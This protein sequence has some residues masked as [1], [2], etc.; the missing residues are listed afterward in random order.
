MNVATSPFLDLVEP[1]KAKP[2]M[3]MS[4][5]KATLSLTMRAMDPEDW[6]PLISKFDGACQEMTRVFAVNRWPKV[7]LEPVVFLADG[8]PVAG[9]MVMVQH[10]PLGVGRMAIIKWGPTMRF[11]DR[12]DTNAIYEQAIELLV[13]EYCNKRKM[14]MSIMAR[15][16][17][18]ETNAELE[19]LT[20]KGFKQGEQLKF[21]DRYIVNLHQDDDELRAGLGQKWRYHFKK[22]EKA[23]LEFEHA[24]GNAK[25]WEFDVLYQ[26]MTDRKRFPDYSAYH[27]VEKLMVADAPELRP[28]MF[29]VRKDGEAVAGALIFKAGK[30]AVYLYGA[31]NDK[32]LPLRAGYFMHWHIIRWLRDNT[33]A[34]WYDLGGTDGFQ[35]LHQFKK[36]MVGTSGVVTPVPPIMNYASSPIAFGLGL[37]AFAARDAVNEVKRIVNLVRSDMARPNQER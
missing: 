28:E 7:D 2:Q 34:Q 26:A 6:D 9:A 33:P 25:L 20:K 5:G 14:M 27:T 21:P 1:A 15:A 18:S 32:A 29:F 10:L 12:A 37:S 16:S 30:T 23:G 36:G 24:P 8:E 13:E 4:N 22:S 35:G 19:F 31:T 17:K 11:E 3:V